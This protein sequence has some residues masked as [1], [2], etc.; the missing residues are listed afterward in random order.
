[1]QD[2]ASTGLAAYV[3]PF[4]AAARAA[5]IS[6]RVGEGNSVSCGGRAG[7][8][9]V[10]AS[11]LWAVDTLLACAAV[12]VSTFN[13]HGGLHGAY[14]P[15]A[16][17]ALPTSNVPDVRPLYVAMLA[18]AEITAHDSVI[19]SAPTTS[20]NGLIKGWALRD[21][22]NSWRVV[23][24]HKGYNATTPATVTVHPPVPTA[25][26]AA[27]ARLEVRGGSNVSATHGILW[28]GQTFDGSVDGAP[29]GTRVTEPVISSSGAWTFS[30]DPA[31][32]AVLEWS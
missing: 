30:L 8:S 27:L 6:F 13:F 26:T 32:V 9:D 28:A 4:A 24:I 25:A 20:S 22:R 10:M 16:F 31:T 3:A 14:T 1:M 19:L 17:P 21:A 2:A 15:I 7:V 23:V 5:G 29:V 12:N 11:A 18:V